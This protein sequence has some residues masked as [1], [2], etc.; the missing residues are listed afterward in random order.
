MFMIEPYY[1]EYDFVLQMSLYFL[2]RKVSRGIT[3]ILALI[4]QAK[5][6]S[7]ATSR[8]G[9]PTNFLYLTK[10]V[11]ALNDFVPGL[12]TERHSHVVLR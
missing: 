1:F 8:L 7:S 2:D 6:D 3:F 4:W 11:F 5:N 10:V 12:P 9:I